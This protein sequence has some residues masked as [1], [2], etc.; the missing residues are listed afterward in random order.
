M[1]LPTTYIA[2]FKTLI[3]RN[4]AIKSLDAKSRVPATTISKYI[5]LKGVLETLRVNIMSAK[6]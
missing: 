6:T 5:M 4:E 3:S 2:I 1:S